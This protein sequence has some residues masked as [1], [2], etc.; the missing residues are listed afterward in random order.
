[1]C[2]QENKCGCIG[3]VAQRVMSCQSG[4]IGN[5]CVTRHEVADHFRTHIF[6]SIKEDCS[7]KKVESY[8]VSWLALRCSSSIRNGPMHRL[9][10]TMETSYDPSFCSVRL[11]QQKGF[12]CRKNKATKKQKQKKTFSMTAI[13]F[14]I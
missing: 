12:S 3:L 5:D 7:I 11:K 2:W 10:F 9:R 8:L 4:K 13:Y 1:M 14:L 6:M